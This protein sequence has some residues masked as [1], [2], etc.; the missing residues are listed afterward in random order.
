MFLGYVQQNT[1]NLIWYVNINK[2]ANIYNVAFTA[3]GNTV[4]AY[5]QQSASAAKALIIYLHNPT[6]Y[7]SNNIS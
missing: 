6:W 1:C 5:L 2:S 3:N 4:M 7:D